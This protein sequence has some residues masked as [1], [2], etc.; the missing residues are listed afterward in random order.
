VTRV[1]VG[2]AEFGLENVDDEF[3][4][5]IF[6]VAV[7]LSKLD[8]EAEI[9]LVITDDEHMRKL[10]L[11][12]RGKDSTTNVLSFGYLETSSEGFVAPGDEH[13]VGDIY[14]SRP[15][16]MEEAKEMGITE[17]DRFLQ[18]FVHAIL[19]LAGMDHLTDLDAETMEA[20][21]DVIIAKVLE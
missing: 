2:Y 7:S 16:V 14:I 4:Q 15:K 20:L 11:Q 17:R 19:H 9:G 5:F 1:Y 18:L 13:Y 3:I 21:E 10:N 8:A 6:D 12:Y